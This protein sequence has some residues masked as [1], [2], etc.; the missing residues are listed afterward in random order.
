MDDVLI[1][2]GS[3]AGL[4]AAMHLARA[5]RRVTILDTNLPRNRYA[6][7]AHNVLGLD[8]VSPLD[9][10]RQGLANVLAYPTAR[11][12]EAEAVG[13]GGASDDFVVRG[14]GGET[15]TARRV[16]LSYGVRDQFPDIPG[17]A[18]CWGKTV[19]HCPY[20]HGY[21]VADRPMGVLYSS[22][23]SLHATVL[24]RDWSSDLT[25]FTNGTE[26]AHE[27]RAVIE[28]RGVRIEAA[29]IAAILHDAGEM[30]AVRLAEGGDVPLGAMLAHP[31]VRPS[32]RLHEDIGVAIKDTPMGP[33]ME[34]SD[35]FE[36][37]VPGV[38]AAGDIARLPHSINSATFSGMMAGVGL[39]RSLLDWG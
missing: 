14:A 36:T 34:V 28:A 17:F 33:V 30:R 25:L 29:P 2:G 38:F 16:L 23:N 6:S 4:V 11:H 7:A 24:I 39:H 8:G 3:F 1:V 26:L 27:D 35:A 31:P 20:C 22:P 13:L 9:I 5:R 12:I 32:S 19:I 18:E 21:E 37:S 15:Y 10:R